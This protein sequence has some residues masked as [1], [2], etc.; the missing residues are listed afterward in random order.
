MTVLAAGTHGRDAA[1]KSANGVRSNVGH[2]TL[3]KQADRPL[4]RIYT[5]LLYNPRPPKY[6]TPPMSIWNAKDG[7]GSTIDYESYSESQ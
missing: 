5:S 1:D 7:R 6:V 2:G 3:H 4:S